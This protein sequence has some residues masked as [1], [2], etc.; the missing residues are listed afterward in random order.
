MGM[1]WPFWDPQQNRPRT[2]REVFAR[3][4]R[5]IRGKFKGRRA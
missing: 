5:W 2:W 4:W 3:F 1:P